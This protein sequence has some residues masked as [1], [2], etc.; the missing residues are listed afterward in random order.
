M[1]VNLGVAGDVAAVR[2]LVAS[3]RT[4]PF[5]GTL[6]RQ[7]AQWKDLTSAIHVRTPD[8]SF[9]VMMN[10]WLMY[11]TLSCRLWGRSGFYQASGAYGFR[12][13]L[14]DVMAIAHVRPD[15]ARQHILRA[16][17][18][19][20][21]EGDVQHWWLPDT[22]AGV[23][24]HISDDVVWLAYCTDTY[25]TLTGDW[26][27]LDEEVPFV[28]GPAVPPH[29]HDLFAIPT[30][31][32][33]RG[34]LYEHCLSGLRHAL[35]TG[36]HG[37]P[38]MGTG[39]W[40]DGMNHVGDGGQGE[41]IWLGWFLCAVLE[42][43]A[44]LAEMRGDAAVV[45][46][47]TTWRAKLS[48]AIDEKGW[49]GAWYLRA[50][51]DDQTPL[52]TSGARECRIDT[53][54]QSWAVLSK[55]GDPARAAQALASAD[56]RLVDWQAGLAHLFWPPL[57]RH[58]PHA[59]YVQS[60]PAGVRENG[61]QYTH[62]AL[63]SVF[64]HAQL[65]HTDMAH[66]LFSLMNPVDH[67]LTEEAARLYRVEPYAM[68]ADIYALAGQVGRGGW[69]WYTGA[70]GWAFRAGLEAILGFRREGSLLRLRPCVPAAWP[71]FEVSYRFEGKTLT[72]IFTRG[73]GGAAEE[74]RVIDLAAAEDGARFDV[75]L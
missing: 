33:A 75:T 22:G 27:I 1:T 47:F 41:S 51:F 20:F 55:A 31:S 64:A 49:D 32:G 7:R 44:R 39:D 25:M 35:R 4:T 45:E 3:C 13:Q 58:E 17:A 69:T 62:G 40:N 28:E 63:W 59:G 65:G 60:Y 30:D 26:S 72:F 68:A 12:D 56:A 57:Q 70:A 23:R 16:A 74:E 46:E 54:A 14:Q 11:Q 15:L 6:A 43:F 66:K 36:P 52:G 53:I 50:F 8:P 29:A 34:T 21:H 48:S 61:G 5:A 9:D 73:A 2:A 19:Q 67:A 37:L 18:R 42:R 38:L 71:S 24:T 10:G